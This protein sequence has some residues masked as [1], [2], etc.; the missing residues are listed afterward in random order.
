LRSRNRWLAD[1]LVVI[2]I[3]AAA[4]GCAP[5]R[6]VAPADPGTPVADHAGLWQQAAGSC[7][8][9]RTLT[10]ELALSGRAGETGLRGRVQAGFAPGGIRLEGVAPFGQPVFILV[11]TPSDAT[12]LLP[13]DERVVRAPNA[14]EIL[15]ALVGVRLEAGALGSVLTG[16]G[17]TGEPVGATEHGDVVRFAFADGAV[18]ARRRAGALRIVAAETQSFLIEYP[19][20]FAGGSAF[21]R[22][23][24]ISRNAAG[25]D[26]VDLTIELAQIETN[27]DLPAAAFTVDVPPGTLPM[28]IAQLRSAG[29]LGARN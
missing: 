24:R 18:F 10:A 14:S 22:R 16:C 29:P 3:A 23:V 27:V 4:G 5:K 17:V 11:G 6:F 21:P 8:G 7:R 12:L 13:R 9:V 28:T 15:D 25:A 1:A 20:A 19:D 2:A 26:R